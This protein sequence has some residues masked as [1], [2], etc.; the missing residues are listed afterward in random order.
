MPPPPRGGFCLAGAIPDELAELPQFVIWRYEHRQGKPTK[1]PHTTM[2]YRADVT[3]PDHWSTFNFC[4]KMAARPG[5]ADGVGFVFTDA[6]PY[7][8]ID[9]DNIY[10]SD[11][12]DCVPWAAG[13]LER[14]RD[15]YSELSPSGKGVKIWVRAQAPRS[16]RWP[17]ESG[18]IEVYDRS[19]FFT[20]T[21][22][23]AGVFAITDH[24]NDIDLLVENLDTSRNVRGRSTSPAQ[25][26]IPETI[27]EGHRHNSLVS[28][29][30]TMFRRGMCVESIEA[31][32]LEVNRVQCGGHYGP[33]HIRQ[34]MR[35]TRG[36][37]Q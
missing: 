4:L 25:E 9:L 33:D 13:I 5:F 24:Q 2:G 15:T 17:V 31:A 26:R 28:L 21:G 23:S 37:E 34:I 36:W 8:G 11:A 20:V 7:C 19:R 12:T 6:D 27:P 1:V 35:S 16:G 10:P 22:Q 14:F 18:L 29:A 30:G 32:L 3:N